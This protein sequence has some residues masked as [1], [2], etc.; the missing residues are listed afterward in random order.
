MLNNCYQKKQKYRFKNE[1]PVADIRTEKT[2]PLFH[3]QM[4]TE[5]NVLARELGHVLENALNQI[6]EDHRLVF[7]LRELNGL[8]TK[9]TAE[10][11]N[12][13][14]ANVK[15]RLNRAKTMLRS[16]IGKMYSPEDIYEFNLVYCNRMV[17]T[18]MAKIGAQCHK[19]KSGSPVE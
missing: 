17:E 13:S 10:T 7:T 4:N 15:T 3:N 8:S 11:V 2:I 18:V 14:E 9:E 12:T 5:K 16:E 6:P 19:T 1:T